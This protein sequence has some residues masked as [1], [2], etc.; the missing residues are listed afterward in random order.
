M[1][2]FSRPTGSAGRGDRF[3]SC[4]A[5]G[6]R[7]P[8]TWRDEGAGRNQSGFSLRDFTDSKKEGAAMRR[9]SESC[10]LGCFL[11]GFSCGLRRLLC[12]L[13]RGELLLDLGSDGVGVHLVHGSGLVEY[14]SRV[15]PGAHVED[16]DFNQD[17]TQYALFGTTEIGGKLLP[18]RVAGFGLLD[19]VPAG[20]DGQTAFVQQGSQSLG[21]EEQVTSHQ[22]NRDSLR[23]GGEGADASSVGNRNL[24]TL[25]LLPRLRLGVIL[26]LLRTRLR[27]MHW[28]G[29]LRAYLTNLAFVDAFRDNGF[30]RK[31]ARLELRADRL[32]F[33]GGLLGTDFDIL[34]AGNGGTPILVLSIRRADLDQL[35]LR[36]DGL[37]DVH[38]QLDGVAFRIGALC[39][40][41]ANS[42]SFLLA[43]GRRADRVGQQATQR[44]ASTGMSGRIPISSEELL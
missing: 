44:T 19:T 14:L 5:A 11:S 41:W 37:P 40:I 15:M 13:F 21:D 30:G 3:G 4:R 26:D 17:T 9:P 29:W 7:G 27:V 39:G 20:N 8:E 34:V 12:F 1:D 33:V 43:P 31:L 2:T 28:A 42:K 6:E 36:G 16:G 24:P 10:L 23:D 35:R 38:L 22:P 25:P 32:F 18:K